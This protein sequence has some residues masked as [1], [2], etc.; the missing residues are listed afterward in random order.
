MPDILFVADFFA[1]QVPGGGELNESSTSVAAVFGALTATLL[2]TGICWKA[3]VL[4]FQILQISLKRTK[5]IY[6]IE[7]MSFMSTITSISLGETQAFTQSIM[8]LK[9]ISLIDNFMQTQGLFYVRAS[10]TRT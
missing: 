4:L 9:N 3:N 10:F 7:T 1:H 6:K 5:K 2:A 8:H